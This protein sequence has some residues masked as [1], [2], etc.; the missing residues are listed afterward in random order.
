[1][2]KRPVPFVGAGTLTKI[3]ADLVLRRATIYMSMDV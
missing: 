2:L 3:Q 1:M